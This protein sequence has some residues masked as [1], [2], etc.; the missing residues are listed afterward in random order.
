[1]GVE[2]G[3]EVE[4]GG[5]DA[6][7]EGS[8][9]EGGEAG[10]E[11]GGGFGWG[12]VAFGADGE[13]EGG[14]E[15]GR[16]GGEPGGDGYGV[17]EEGAESGGGVG[18]PGRGG[19]DGVEGLRGGDEGKP[20]VAGLFAGGEGDGGPAGGLAGGVGGFDADD[21]VVGLDGDDAGGA[22]FDGFLDDPVHFLLADEGLQ[23]PKGGGG[24]GDEAGGEDAQADV[25][26]VGVEDGGGGDAPGPVK[27]F[28]RHAL[29]EAHDGGEMVR[30][31]LGQ[32][33]FGVVPEVRGKECADHGRGIRGRT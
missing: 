1:V 19:Q 4:G 3:E 31:F 30:F 10:G 20:G 22:E 12:E 7:D 17:G 33:G 2:G 8:E 21:G 15:G 11:K 24:A 23:E 32:A 29:L 14:G 27:Q 25:L 5:F 16:E 26:A 9:G 18:G 6:E 13:G 28:R